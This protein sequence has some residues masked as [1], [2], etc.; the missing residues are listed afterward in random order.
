MRRRTNAQLCAPGDSNAP[1][2]GRTA[3]R[4]DVRPKT[5]R[6]PRLPHL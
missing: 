2:Y 5:Q 1:L 3:V 4:P 6:S